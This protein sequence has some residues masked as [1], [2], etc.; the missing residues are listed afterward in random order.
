MRSNARPVSTSSFRIRDRTAGSRRRS[1]ILAVPPSCTQF[2]IVTASPVEEA[3][4]GYWSAVT[5]TPS[6]R[7]L[8]MSAVDYFTL[9]QFFW[10]AAL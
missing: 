8:S 1:H 9:P 10:P 5:S 2:G 7:A 6:A 4:Y 3:V